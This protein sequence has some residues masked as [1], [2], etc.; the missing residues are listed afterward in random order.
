[1]SADLPVHRIRPAGER[2]RPL[3]T[4]LFRYR[5]LLAFLIWRSVKVRYAQSALGV[6]WAVV[7]PVA[8]MVVFTLIFG[9]LVGVESDGA[10][11][12]VFTFVALVPWTYFSNALTQGTQSLS[13]NAGLLSKVYFPRVVLPLSEIGARSV[14]FLIAFVILLGLVLTYRIIPN[15]GVL[16]LPLL[17]IIIVVAA[18]GLSLGLS[19]LAIQY[20]DINHAASFG[21]QLLMYAAPVVYPYSAVPDSVRLFYALNPMVGVVEGF[22]AAILG[23]RDMPWLE[24]GLGGL[25]A[26]V[27]L[28]AGSIYFNSREHLFA[29]VA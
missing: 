3:L 16:V 29:D 7:Q 1:M 25:T 9:K 2:A 21:V 24:I 18:A 26:T 8:Q 4:E 28:I 13:S 5:E 15:T 12:A 23:T 22:R 14:D 10:P 11:Y 19:A 27:L 17:V 20:R 6:G